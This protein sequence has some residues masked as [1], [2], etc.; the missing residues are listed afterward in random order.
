VPGNWGPRWLLAGIFWNSGQVCVSGSRLLVER[1]IHDEFVAELA[2]VAASM[3]VGDPLDITTQSG[4][5]NNAMQLQQN[6]QFVE[7]A[8]SEGET[9]YQEGNQILQS[10][11]GYYMEPTIVTDVGKDHTLVQKEAFGPVLAVTA[12]DDEHEAFALANSTEL[13]LTLD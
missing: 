1:S 7:T 6:L 3:K 2:S 13:G 12:F 9:L 10:T 4:A 11:G 5:I 8:Q